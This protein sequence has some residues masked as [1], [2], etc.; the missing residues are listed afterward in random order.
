MG[1]QPALKLRPFFRGM[2]S[3]DRQRRGIHEDLQ[4]GEGKGVPLF[5]TSELQR[6]SPTMRQMAAID[7]HHA[8]MWVKYWRSRAYI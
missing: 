4:L 5:D 6:C 7:K 3:T 2:A 1:T 8:R